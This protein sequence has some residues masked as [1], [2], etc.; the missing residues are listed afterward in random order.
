MVDSEEEYLQQFD[1]GR[2]F[3]E[4]VIEDPRQYASRMQRTLLPEWPEEVLIE[5]LYRHAGH[6]YTYAFLRYEKFHFERQQWVLSQI[7]GKE[8]FADPGFF[9]G[10]QDIEQRAE[11][12]YD[13]LAQ[14]MLKHGTW[15]TPILLLQTPKHK[16]NGLGELAV[17]LSVAFIR[18]A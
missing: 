1:P 4:W 11:D 17:T 6:I 8:V 5:W 14:F 18:R 2:D 13:W 3:A 15:N 10:F 16:I 12:P 9:E 7:P